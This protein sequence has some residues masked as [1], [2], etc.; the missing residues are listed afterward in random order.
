MGM[1]VRMRMGMIV[2]V[3]MIMIVPVSVLKGVA[4]LVQVEQIHCAFS[5]RIS[6]FSSSESELRMAVVLS[7]K[8]F[9]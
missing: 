8:I 4:L 7:S 1:L 9:L 3:V 5:P 2:I 6:T